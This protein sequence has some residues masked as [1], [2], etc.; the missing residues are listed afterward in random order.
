MATKNI[1]SIQVCKCVFE[2]HLEG[3]KPG[4]RFKRAVEILQTITGESTKVCQAAINREINKGIVEFGIHNSVG[5]LT[6]KGIELIKIE[7]IISRK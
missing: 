5:W 4:W 2:M 1:T 3:I 7:N 6:Y